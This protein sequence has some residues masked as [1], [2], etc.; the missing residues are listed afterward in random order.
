M[1]SAE[2]KTKE[3]HFCVREVVITSVLEQGPPCVRVGGYVRYHLSDEPNGQ[4]LLA[5]CI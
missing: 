2:T 5:I 1:I 4:N 3:E